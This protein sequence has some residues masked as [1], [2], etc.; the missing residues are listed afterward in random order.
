MLSDGRRCWRSFQN[1]LEYFAPAVPPRVPQLLVECVAEIERRGLQ[2]VSSA[3]HLRLQHRRRRV[4]TKEKHHVHF[5]CVRVCVCACAQRGLYRVPGGERL[6]KE[7]KDRFLEGKAPPQLNK[8]HD[9]HVICGVLKDFLRKLKEPL[10]TFKLHRAF[11]EAA[12]T[13]K[14]QLS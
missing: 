6:V 11:G 9:I 14:N 8:V 10:V 13:S 5:L 1:S 12:G 3:S 4:Q 7:L 2:E